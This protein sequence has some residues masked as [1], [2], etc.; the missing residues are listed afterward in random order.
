MREGGGR[1]GVLLPARVL[2]AMSWPRPCPCPCPA[3]PGHRE[4]PAG[5][6]HRHGL[7]QCVSVVLRAR[8]PALGP[9]AGP[10]RQQLERR[11]H[12]RRLQSWPGQHQD[13]QA[14]EEQRLRKRVRETESCC[15]LI[16]LLRLRGRTFTAKPDF[17]LLD[18]PVSLLSSPRVC[19]ALSVGVCCVCLVRRFFNPLVCTA[20]T[21]QHAQVEGCTAIL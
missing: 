12:R 6:A 9:E 15:L 14:E 3:P 18:L 1:G 13:C 11:V 8:G 19:H 2:A 16:E 7:R 20:D 5:A 17:L 4:P 10:V 21:L